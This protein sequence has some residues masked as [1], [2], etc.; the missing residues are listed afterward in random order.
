MSAIQKVL[1]QYSSKETREAS[2]RLPPKVYRELESDIKS[3]SSSELL[4]LSMIDSDRIKLTK[5]K[6]VSLKVTDTET[7][8]DGTVLVHLDI[9]ISFK[10]ADVVMGMGTEDVAIYNG[11]MSLSTV[12]PI[13]EV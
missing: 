8:P 6:V 12:L 1:A 4:E 13:P 10:W 11:H 9:D 7:E 2:N 5:H 3:M